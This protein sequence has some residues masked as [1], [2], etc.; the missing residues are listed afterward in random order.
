M[1]K[2][3]MASL[4]DGYGDEA[5]GCGCGYGDGD[6]EARFGY[7]DGK[8]QSFSLFPSYTYKQVPSKKKKLR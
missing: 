5:L 4:G 8:L 2:K 6:A 3:N 7:G 1:K